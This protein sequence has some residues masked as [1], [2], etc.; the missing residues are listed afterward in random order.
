MESFRA[1]GQG[2]SSREGAGDTVKFPEQGFL[3]CLN[4]VAPALAVV[5][6]GGMR[7]AGEIQ[8]EEGAEA[9]DD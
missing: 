7:A 4:L 8:R 9:G 3:L 2:R 6:A 1:N 5:F